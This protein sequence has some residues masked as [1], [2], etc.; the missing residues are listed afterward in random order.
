MT[1]LDDG[2]RGIAVTHITYFTN[3]VILFCPPQTCKLLLLSLLSRTIY[4]QVL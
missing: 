3:G 1:N 4:H 2:I